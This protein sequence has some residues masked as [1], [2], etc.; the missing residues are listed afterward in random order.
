MLDE[1]LGLAASWEAFESKG[2][3]P[4]FRKP[5]PALTAS[6]LGV[7][8]DDSPLESDV[9]VEAESAGSVKIVPPQATPVSSGPGKGKAGKGKGGNESTPKLATNAA[10]LTPVV[11]SPSVAENKELVAL[12]KMRHWLYHFSIS[13]DMIATYS[14]CIITSFI[15][16]MNQ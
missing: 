3:A 5:L 9:V 4:K 1:A 8:W 2:V 11:P 7:E 13:L 15:P 10:A 6:H 14:L 12:K 16:H